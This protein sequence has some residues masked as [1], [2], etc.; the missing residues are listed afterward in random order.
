MSL[1]DNGPD[2]VT[3]YPV[4]N[5][6]DGYGGSQPGSGDPVRV[7]ARVVPVDSDEDAENG[8]VAGA[9]YRVYARRLPTG[10]WSRVEWA[11]SV[12]SVV[13]EPA[14]FGGSRRIAFHV[15]TIRKRA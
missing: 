4:V 6:P 15:A 8:Y 13:G 1:L 11:G 14:R 5:V 12:W 10:P 2:V 3:V 7:R 9:V